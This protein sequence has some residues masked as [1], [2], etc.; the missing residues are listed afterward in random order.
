MVN[1]FAVAGPN[2]KYRQPDA[3]PAGFWAGVWHGM[4]MPIAFIVSLFNEGVGIYETHNAGWRYNL[5]FVLGASMAH[6]GG[7][8]QLHVQV[9]KTRVRNRSWINRR[10]PMP[11][12]RILPICLSWLL[13]SMPDAHGSSRS[14]PVT[15]AP[16]MPTSWLCLPALSS[17]AC[18]IL[19][20]G[21]GLHP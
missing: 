21:L 2:S 6:G 20:R 1:K 14:T 7:H 18:V 15:T 12:W 19:L 10:W 8:R 13:H 4:I 17:C 3:E 11:D 16:V 9:G 5:G